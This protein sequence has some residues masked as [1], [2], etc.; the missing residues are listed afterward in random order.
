VTD[1]KLT[2][3]SELLQLWFEQHYAYNKGLNELLIEVARYGADRELEACCEW[4]KE[5]WDEIRA[6]KLRAARRPKTPSLKEQAMDEL[7]G[8]AAVFRMSHGGDLVCDK[9]RRALEALPND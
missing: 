9:I 4:L 1:P 8:I 7:D 2:P 3:P 6:D 5:G